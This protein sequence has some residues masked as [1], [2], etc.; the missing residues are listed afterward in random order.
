MFWGCSSEQLHAFPGAVDVRRSG[1]REG[2]GLKHAHVLTTTEALLAP[3]GELG[4][5]IEA[6][7]FYF[8]HISINMRPNYSKQNANQSGDPLLSLSFTLFL[9]FF[10][11]INVFQPCCRSFFCPDNTAKDNIW[12]W[13]LVFVVIVRSGD[14]Y[15]LDTA[16]VTQLVFCNVIRDRILSWWHPDTSPVS[17]PCLL[18]LPLSCNTHIFSH[19]SDST[20]QSNNK[21]NPN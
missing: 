8:H 3:D 11:R 1:W 16:S 14:D 4:L 12:G 10:F 19:I 2:C 7:K 20:S 18:Y 5:W 15:T 9:N 21:M 13:I 17:L 6:L